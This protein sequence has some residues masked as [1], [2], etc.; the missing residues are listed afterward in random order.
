MELITGRISL[1]PRG[2]FPS[3]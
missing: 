1:A 2:S 3:F